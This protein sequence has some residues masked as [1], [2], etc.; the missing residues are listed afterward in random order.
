M[1]SALHVTIIAR[2]VNSRQMSAH[3]ANFLSSLM[4]LTISVKRVVPKAYLPTQETNV[5]HV[6]PCVP[7]ANLMT[8]IS[9]L[10]AKKD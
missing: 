5:W 9:A 1:V 8:K 4:R 6:T 2:P 10:L 3:L 7:H